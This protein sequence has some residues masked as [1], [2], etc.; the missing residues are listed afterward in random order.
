[1]QWL[2]LSLRSFRTAYRLAHTVLSPDGEHTFVIEK[3]EGVRLICTEISKTTIRA[4]EDEA[5]ERTIER[6]L[7]FKRALGDGK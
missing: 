5:D 2:R 7:K 6:K 1:M 3:V 4:M